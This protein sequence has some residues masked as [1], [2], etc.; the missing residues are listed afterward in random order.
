MA[1]AAQQAAMT[2]LTGATLA[3]LPPMGQP[4]NAYLARPPDHAELQALLVVVVVPVLG[5]D[6]PVVHVKGAGEERQLVD[7]ESRDPLLHHR[8]RRLVHER[9]RPI[10]TGPVVAIYVDA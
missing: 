2:A 8:H 9:V 1:M 4:S 6:D 3:E 7:H 5:I 10:H